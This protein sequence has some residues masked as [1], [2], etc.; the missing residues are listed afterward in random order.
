MVTSEIEKSSLLLMDQ[1]TKVFFLKVFIPKMHA[2]VVLPGM[3][4]DLDTAIEESR[5]ILKR[6]SISQVKIYPAT[7]GTEPVLELSGPHEPSKD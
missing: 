4:P 1:P 3:I 7:L 2:W 5:N 6:E